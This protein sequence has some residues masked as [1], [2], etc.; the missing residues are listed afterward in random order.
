MMRIS[1][2]WRGLSRDKRGAAVIELAIAAPV[3]AGL[4]VGMVDLGRAYSTKLQLEQASQ[5][6]VEKVM[7]GQATVETRTALKREA[8]YLAGVD[9]SAVTVEFFLECENVRQAS[10]VT[11]CPANQVSARYMTVSITKVYTPMFAKRFAGA[12]ANGTYTLTGFT[13][14]RT[15]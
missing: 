7:N 15:Q 13:G 10:S 5:S 2:T 8:A 14:V 3:F 6:A 11:N 12:S 9:E 4:L 1:G